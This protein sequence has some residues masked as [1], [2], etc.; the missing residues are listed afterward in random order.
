MASRY[1]SQALYVLCYVPYWL[2]SHRYPQGA[3]AILEF[4]TIESP[5]AQPRNAIIGHIISAAVGV[6][7][8]K[9]FRLNADFEDLR[10]LAGA[11]ACGLAS[12]AMTVTNTVYPPSGA[13]ALLAAVDPQVERLGWYL[14][15]LVLLSGT[16]TLITSL[17]INNI[18]RR[19]PT[20]WWTPANV[21]RASETNDIEKAPTK[22]TMNSDCSS[23][24]A[25]PVMRLGSA[26]GES[27]IRIAADSIVVPDGFY[28]AEEE[29]SVLEILQ[30]RFR[31]GLMRPLETSSQV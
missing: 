15:P 3:A 10:W 30:D 17:I 2:N 18:Q 25:G 8:T 12:A 7:I 20:F 4:N 22:T 23:S 14:L 27:I 11:L 16:L 31:H 29:K 26:N 1:S 19:Y 5:L 24:L 21:G 28:L 9:L 13:T 6:G